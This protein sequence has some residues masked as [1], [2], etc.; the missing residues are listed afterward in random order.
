MNRGIL[1]VLAMFA[2]VYECTKCGDVW[3][4]V[5]MVEVDAGPDDTMTIAVCNC[6]REVRPKMNGNIP[7]FHALTDEEMDLEMWEPPGDYDSEYDS[8]FV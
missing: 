4:S 2:P 1:K 5:S 8:D 7:V 3:R 6:G